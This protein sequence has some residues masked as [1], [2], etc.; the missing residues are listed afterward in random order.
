MV[1]TDAQCRS[2]TSVDVLGRTDE[3]EN[4]RCAELASD[5]CHPMLHSSRLQRGFTLVELVVVTGIIVLVSAIVFANNTRFGGRVL[6]QNLAYDTA[7]TIRQAQAYAMSV[8][9]SDSQTIPGFG[10]RFSIAAGIDPD[11]EQSYNR[12]FKIYQDMNLDGRYST[13]ESLYKRPYRIGR[14]GY[15]ISDLCYTDPSGTEYCKNGPPTDQNLN[16]ID[17]VFKRPDADACIGVKDNPSF[18]NGVCGGPGSTAYS[19][20]RILLRGPQGDT[21]SVVVQSTGQISVQ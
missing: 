4:R 20:A 16:I 6:L 5:S 21:K 9:L 3:S 10:V 7:L 14:P 18:S 1:R 2:T 8:A 13:G 17:I 11:T 12:G 19:R 15:S